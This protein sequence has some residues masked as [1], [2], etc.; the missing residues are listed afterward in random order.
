[1]REMA[2]RR[3]FTAVPG[4][5]VW[6]GAMACTKVA[7]AYMHDNVCLHASYDCMRACYDCMHTRMHCGAYA[8]TWMQMCVYLRADSR[9]CKWTRVFV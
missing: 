3:S 7:Y 2:P 6:T 1:M 8:M 5:G 4:L 9:L